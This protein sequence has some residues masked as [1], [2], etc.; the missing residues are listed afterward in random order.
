[1][2]AVSTVSALLVTVLL[3]PAIRGFS[4]RSVNRSP[5]PAGSVHTMRATIDPAKVAEVRSTFRFMNDR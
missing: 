3:T 4:I 5:K 2:C 1:M